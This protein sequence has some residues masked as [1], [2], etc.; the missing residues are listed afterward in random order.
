MPK[1]WQEIWQLCE[2]RKGEQGFTWRQSKA[3][4]LK[5]GTGTNSRL[6][7]VV[8]RSMSY[9]PTRD[10]NCLCSIQVDACQLLRVEERPN[11]EATFW[12]EL[13]LHAGA[14]V[15]GEAHSTECGVNV[16]RDHEEAVCGVLADKQVNV[17][18]K[19]HATS[20]RKHSQTLWVLS[21]FILDNPWV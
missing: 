15:W 10:M 14:C 2:H 19:L 21:G 8:K 6:K 20:Y 11:P 7:M 4:K 16:I 13:S 12:P 17:Q 9:C 5:P 1:L 18:H 3:P